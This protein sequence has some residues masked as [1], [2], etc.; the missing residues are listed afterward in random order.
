MPLDRHSVTRTDFPMSRRGYDR[1]AVDRHLDDVAQQIDSLQRPS[2][3]GATTSAQVQSILDAAEAS[4]AEIERRAWDDAT[5]VQEAT[6]ESLARARAHIGALGE[7]SHVLRQRIEALL[8]EVES[9][10]GTLGS[11]VAEPA[12]EQLGFEPDD[13]MAFDPILEDEVAEAALAETPEPRAAEARFG[14]EPEEVNGNGNGHGRTEWFTQGPPAWTGA[15]VTPAAGAQEARDSARL[16][17]LNMADGGQSREAT[18]AYLSG[19]YTPEE[20]AALLDEIY[21]DH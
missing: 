12:P 16:V 4:A 14:R 6:D 19:L 9:L 8:V 20:R 2:S 11:L 21:G 7:A 17:A 10:E 1:I 15:A 13:T 18:D 5:R 3:V